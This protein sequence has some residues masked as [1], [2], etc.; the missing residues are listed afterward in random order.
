MWDWFRFRAVPKITTNLITELWI[1]TTKTSFGP[2]LEVWAKKQT[3]GWRTKFQ[4]QRTPMCRTS[5]RKDF[6]GLQS[7][8]N[9]SLKYTIQVYFNTLNTNMVLKQFRLKLEINLT[10]IITNPRFSQ[11]IKIPPKS[12]CLKFYRSFNLVDSLKLI[13]LENHTSNQWITSITLLWVTLESKVFHSKN[14]VLKTLFSKK[15]VSKKNKKMALH[16]LKKSKK[17]NLLTRDSKV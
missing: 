14:C 4:F 11:W 9:S 15:H 3:N 2:V 13:C 6:K 7:L 16:K 12:R 5:C 8:A 1:E 10:N 17:I